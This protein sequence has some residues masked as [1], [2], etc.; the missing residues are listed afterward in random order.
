MYAPSADQWCRWKL[1][2]P[3]S[4]ILAE[5]FAIIKAVEFSKDRHLQTVIFT[6]GKASL[7]LLA[8]NSPKSYVNT[9]FEI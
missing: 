7:F 6:D 8:S 3:H 2:E 4:V 1:S 9:V 5:L